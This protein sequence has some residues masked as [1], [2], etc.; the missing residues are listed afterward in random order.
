MKISLLVNFTELKNNF[1]TIKNYVKLILTILVSKILTSFRGSQFWFLKILEPQKLPNW[2]L[3]LTYEWQQKCEIF[4]T[5]LKHF[6]LKCAK[7]FFW[8]K[9]W[10]FHQYGVFSVKMV[11]FLSK[12][13]RFRQHDNFFHWNDNFVIQLTHYCC[14]KSWCANKSM[15]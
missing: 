14:S 11:Y 1:S 13:S 2:N 8:I 12:C 9:Q 10:E 5:F 3:L 4:L 6:I 15:K 7:K